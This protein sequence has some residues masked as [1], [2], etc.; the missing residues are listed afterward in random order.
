MTWKGARCLGVKTVRESRPTL[1]E[2]VKKDLRLAI[3][4]PESDSI[5]YINIPGVPC[6]GYCNCHVHAPPAAVSEAAEQYP[7]ARK[8]QCKATG[9][10]WQQIH[11]K[12]DWISMLQV[13][14]LWLSQL[15]VI[16]FIRTQAYCWKIIN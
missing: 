8:I 10:K 15:S 16:N 11:V 1:K 6:L 5:E 14:R 9:K 7:G 13:T 4:K 12:Q 3:G 2:G